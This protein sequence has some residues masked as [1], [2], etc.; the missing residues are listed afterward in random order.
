MRRQI[1][2]TSET[3]YFFNR[4]ES[5]KIMSWNGSIFYE[6][7]IFGIIVT[8]FLMKSINNKS[9]GSIFYMITLFIILFSAVP[10]AFPL[11]PMVIALIVYNNNYDYHKIYK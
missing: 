7:G 3:K 5:N 9:R 4:Y 10:V 1:F 8:V 2:D 6:L 11:V